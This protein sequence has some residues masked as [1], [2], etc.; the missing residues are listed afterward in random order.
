[1]AQKLNIPEIFREYSRGLKSFIRKRIKRVEDAEDILQDVFYELSEAQ[2]LMKPVD[3]IA[4]WLYTVTRNL[5]TD[6][7][8]K[9]KPDLVSEFSND[10]QNE[11]GIEILGN[12]LLFSN[13]NPE[14]EYYSS[15]IMEELDNAMKE[16]PPEQREVFGMTEL[17]GMS[18]NEIS[19]LTGIPV[20]TLLS[21]KHYAVLFL[22]ERLKI[23][24]NELTEK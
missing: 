10:D 11:N 15:L 12:I 18:F 6:R 8:R 22:R 17:E 23:L 24:Y 9:K 2:Y 5:I 1:M 19:L 16:L 21:R 3:Q 7:Y 14:T 4:S 20:N 13:D